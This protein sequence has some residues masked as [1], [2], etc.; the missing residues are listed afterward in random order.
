MGD[1]CPAK[2]KS[3]VKFQ[4]DNALYKNG[5]GVAFPLETKIPI[6]TWPLI[7]NNWGYAVS[8]GIPE[9]VVVFELPMALKVLPSWDSLKPTSIVDEFTEPTPNKMR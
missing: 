7:L 2:L 8:C 4:S 3:E 5:D 1:D 9:T 6:T